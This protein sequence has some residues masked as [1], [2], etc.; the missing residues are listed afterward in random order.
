MQAAADP[1]LPRYEQIRE[2]LRRR[3]FAGEWAPGAALP[4]E[5]ELAK[6]YEVALGTMRKA[7]ELMVD[8][9]LIERLHGKGTFVRGEL[10][11]ASMFRFF[12]FRR[13]ADDASPVVPHTVIHA[14]QEATLD[15]RVA[16]RLSLGRARRGIFILRSRELPEGSGLLERIWLPYPPFRELLKLQP[17]DM[18]D[19]LYPFYRSRCGV[20]IARASETIRFATLGRDDAALM[21]MAKGAPVA[22]IERTAF[23]LTGEPV[24]FRITQGD[25][26]KFYYNVEIK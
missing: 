17:K 15:D 22:V 23:S 24:E 18:P 13:D 11:Q 9:G 2:H 12:R 26:A 20:V 14:L 16:E 4:A 7:I 1:R 8:D 10:Q 21:G 3:I 5:T 6:E 19:L 25:A